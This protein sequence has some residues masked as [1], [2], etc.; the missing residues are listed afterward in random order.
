MAELGSDNGGLSSI[1]QKH[2]IVFLT[3]AFLIG[4][5]AFLRF[6]RLD[7]LMGFN[8]DQGRD[9]TII[10][11]MIETGEPT[12][13]GPGSGVGQFK[14]GP[15]YYYLLLPA[16]W[17]SGGE[18]LS[19]IYFIVLVNLAAIL[20]VYVVGRALIGPT[21]GLVAAAMF[22][23]GLLPVVVARAYTNPA[24]LPCLM[25]IMLYA[26][27][28][29]VK[30]DDRF[31]LLLVGAWVIAWQLHDQV[32]LLIPFFAAAWLWFKIRVRVRMLIFALAISLLLLAPF[33]LYETTHNLANL[34]LMVDYV[35]SAGA[36][37]AGEVGVAGAPQ[38]VGE[39]LWVLGHAFAEPRALRLLWSAAVVASGLLLAAREREESPGAQL[40]F[41]YALVPFLFALW[42]GPIYEV[43]VAIVAPV[44]FLLFGYGFEQLTKWRPRWRY[45]VAGLVVLFC[46]YNVYLQYDS[47]QR[48]PIVAYS[49]LSTRLAID[50]IL[51]RTAG[52]PFVMDYVVETRNEEFLSPFQYLLKRRHAAVTTD[53]LAQRVRVYNPAELG[54][55]AGGILI[56]GMRLVTLAAPQPY[57]TNLLSK[58]WNLPANDA[59]TAQ[60]HAAGQIVLPSVAGE[61]VR[62]AVQRVPIDANALYLVQFECRS[63]LSRGEQRLFVSALDAQGNT[64]ETYPDGAGYLCPASAEWTHGAIL[65]QSPANSVRAR[66]LLQNRG[67]GIVK[68]RNVIMQRA[69]QEPLP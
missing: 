57:G 5:G 69:V 54:K 41:L 22:A 39:T 43:N 52:Q 47:L 44:P 46:L 35:R 7:D 21:T 36:E 25:L 24:L 61:P 63:E 55:S 29:L 19:G 4:V 65:F 62:T 1:W 30:G 20:L 68:F 49:Y 32:W 9:V 51:A 64:I 31:F 59:A 58:G 53:P 23:V 14:R 6:Y 15:A 26:L 37:R 33:I 56:H 28:R 17:L 42:P 34:R 13:L 27:W 48:R 11:R 40:L 38:R 12:L 50:E 3:L 66:V 2:R 8:G 10:Q 67:E 16:V 60:D 45:A 18:P